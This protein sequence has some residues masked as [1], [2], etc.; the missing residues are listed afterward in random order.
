MEDN[1]FDRHYADKMRR[2]NAPDFS[3]EDWEKLSPRLDVSKKRKR[4]ISA[5]FLIFFLGGLLLL[6][7]ITWWVIWQQSEQRDNTLLTGTTTG[8][9]VVLQ[10][11][12]WNRVVVYQY[13]TVHRSI[14]PL[15]LAQSF[16]PEGKE[17]SGLVAAVNPRSQERD[18][19]D[20]ITPVDDASVSNAIVSQAGYDDKDA[21]GAGFI[22]SDETDPA[23]LLPV[24]TTFLKKPGKYLSLGEHAVFLAATQHKRKP[25]HP[26]PLYFRL[27]CGAGFMMPDAEDLSSK[28]GFSTGIASEIAF[29]ERLAFTMEGEYL[30]VS[31]KGDEYEEALG[32]PSLPSPGDD[33][34]FKYFETHD[35]FKPVLQL[36]AGLKYWLL[37]SRKI[38]PYLGIGYSSQWHLPYELEVEYT[39]NT[40]G[41]EL[42]NTIEVPS[43]GTP[44]SMLDLNGGLRYRISR[45]WIWQTGMDFQFK[46]D[47]E[48]AGFPRY[49][50]LKSVILYEF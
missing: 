32:L 12:T 16:Y 26:M 24:K 41:L 21:N 44:V 1:D 11:T 27:G 8:G 50:G 5:P 33:Y 29:S 20:K 35:G 6:S 49:W 46:I 10:D 18:A 7:N 31:F 15:S 37:P 23:T 30:G 4:L 14:V 25:Y 19:S 17:K 42:S 28:S 9:T 13:D 39:N 34:E 38:S 22:A 3:H 40:T 48:Q 47:P 43:S 2:V 45:Y 36:T